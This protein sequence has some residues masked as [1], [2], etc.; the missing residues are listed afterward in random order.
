MENKK[1]T[2]QDVLSTIK[3]KRYQL[4]FTVDIPDEMKSNPE[5][6]F[7]IIKN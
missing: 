7:L 4:D 1:F 2:I 6:I 5:V 3:E